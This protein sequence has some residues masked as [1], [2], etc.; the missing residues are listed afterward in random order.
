MKINLLGL[1][2]IWGVSH[3]KACSLFSEIWSLNFVVFYLSYLLLVFSIRCI[4]FICTRLHFSLLF[5]CIEYPQMDTFL[6]HLFFP[7]YSAIC[8]FIQA[9]LFVF[10]ITVSIILMKVYCADSL[11]IIRKW[12]NLQQFSPV[13]L[14]SSDWG[15]SRYQFIQDIRVMFLI[16][17][18]GKMMS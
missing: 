9:L 5:L 14:Q 13:L 6:E 16:R 8:L 3:L 10:S 18:D 12:S 7:F 17:I 1:T 2:T 4:R 15:H 11:I